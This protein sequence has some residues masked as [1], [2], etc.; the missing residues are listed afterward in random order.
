MNGEVFVDATK[1]CNIMVFESADVPFC[2]VALMDPQW[3]KLEV[4]IF[5]MHKWF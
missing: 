1:A 5:F 3:H 2:R 4:D